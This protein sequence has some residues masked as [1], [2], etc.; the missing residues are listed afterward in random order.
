MLVCIR[1]LLM[2][3]SIRST[4]KQLFFRLNQ[5]QFRNQKYK[6]KDIARSQTLDADGWTANQPITVEDDSPGSLDIEK[7]S[8]EAGYGKNRALGQFPKSLTAT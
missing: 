1:S 6:K 7:T 4:I 8:K 3:Q 2:N 5:Q